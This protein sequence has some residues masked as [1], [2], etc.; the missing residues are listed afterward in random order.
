MRP[1]RAAVPF[2][3]H[4]HVAVLVRSVVPQ[5]D[6]VLERQ[7]NRNRTDDYG[8]LLVTGE[9]LH[10]VLLNVLINVVDSIAVVLLRHIISVLRAFGHL[11]AEARHSPPDTRLKR[12]NQP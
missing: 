7:A 11:G 2:I 10:R 9:L 3:A 12:Q 5:L 6:A 8:A 4:V 1:A